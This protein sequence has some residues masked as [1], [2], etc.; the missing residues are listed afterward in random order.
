MD[1]PIVADKTKTYTIDIVGFTYRNN[2][3]EHYVILALLVGIYF[4]MKKIEN[5][6]KPLTFRV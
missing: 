5:V 3:S 2:I 4:D 1:R 6:V